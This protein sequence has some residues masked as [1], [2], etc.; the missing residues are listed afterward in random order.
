M[1][2]IGQETEKETAWSI[3]LL[4]SNNVGLSPYSEALFTL[5]ETNR[6]LADGKDW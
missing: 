4:T 6:S 1:L 2:M 5:A 3:A